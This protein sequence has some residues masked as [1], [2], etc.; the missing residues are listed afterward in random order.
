MAADVYLASIPEHLKVKYFCSDNRYVKVSHAALCDVS[1]LPPDSPI[2]IH[3]YEGD[4][5]QPAAYIVY[6]FKH[7]AAEIYIDLVVSRIKGLGATLLK[8]VRAVADRF[9]YATRFVAAPHYPV[10]GMPYKSELP[11]Y[12]YYRSLGFTPTADFEAPNFVASSVEFYTPFK[13]N[14]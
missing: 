14:E 3:I 12:R 8:V 1:H 6:Y 7:R 11:L 5:S 4:A 9:R 13:V 2:Q 10:E